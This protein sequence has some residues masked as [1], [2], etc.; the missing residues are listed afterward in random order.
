MTEF[1]SLECCTAYV[2]A[3]DALDAAHRAAAA[4]PPVIAD[5]VREVAAN[6]ILL[7]AEAIAYEAGTAAR[8]RCLREALAAAIGLAATLDVARAMSLPDPDAQRLAG[9]AIA[10]LGMFFHANALPSFDEPVEIS[11]QR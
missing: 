11:T 3:R 1:E 4:W 8:R 7:T 2:A 10:M 9:R 6:A 5:Q